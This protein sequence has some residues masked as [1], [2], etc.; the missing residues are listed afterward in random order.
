[1]SLSTILVHGV[2]HVLTYLPFNV[3]HALDTIFYILL[4]W[5]SFLGR[6]W[7]R[8]QVSF[9]QSRFI[10]PPEIGIIID[11]RT[12]LFMPVWVYSFFLH[13]WYFFKKR[14]GVSSKNLK[15]IKKHVISFSSL[16]TF[17]YIYIHT[18]FYIKHPLQF[19]VFTCQPLDI[20]RFAIWTRMYIVYPNTFPLFSL[21][22]LFCFTQHFSFR[23]HWIL[24]SLDRIET[25]LSLL[26]QGANQVCSWY[27]YSDPLILARWKKIGVE[28]LKSV[29]SLS[30]RCK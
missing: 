6:L 26:Y 20:G 7:R 8:Y 12:N 5:Q 19:K 21:F 2:R 17:K 15:D 18:Y 16:R 23:R 29:T 24:Y 28:K 30:G 10:T 22:F 27:V 4:F 1:M 3:H 14:K 25:V 9:P 13:L 11:T